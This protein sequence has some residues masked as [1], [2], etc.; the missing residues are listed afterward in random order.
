MKGVV[1]P[2]KYCPSP[3]INGKRKCFW[4]TRQY[5]KREDN[6]CSGRQSLQ[7]IIKN[8]ILKGQQ[9]SF[10]CIVLFFYL[11]HNHVLTACIVLSN[12]ITLISPTSL[13][14]E[15]H[16]NFMAEEI[17]KGGGIIFEGVGGLTIKKRVVLTPNFIFAFESSE[18]SLF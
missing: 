14:G 1:T 17:Q 4:K 13:R 16:F 6:I 8:W 11:L 18:W 2:T 7:K 5:A 10:S 15:S 9:Y 12:P 3:F